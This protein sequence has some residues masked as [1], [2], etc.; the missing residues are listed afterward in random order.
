[1][2]ILQLILPHVLLLDG[3]AV[4]V[5]P[6]HAWL[7]LRV[8]P[9]PLL[10][11]GGSPTA[12]SSSRCSPGGLVVGDRRGGERGGGDDASLQHHGDEGR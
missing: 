7:L 6:G 12:S 5:A 11:R 9:G 4:L 3:V 2:L 1:M 10:R 8:G